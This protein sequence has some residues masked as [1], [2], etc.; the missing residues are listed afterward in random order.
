MNCSLRWVYNIHTLNL[1]CLF[2]IRGL[3]SYEMILGKIRGHIS[4]L[5]L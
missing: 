1:D 3:L 4:C 5:V 2:T